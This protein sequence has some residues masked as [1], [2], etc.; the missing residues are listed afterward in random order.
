MS[1]HH[2]HHHDHTGTCP[3]CDYGPFVRNAYWT[4]KLMLA[5]DFTDEQRY[6]IDRFRHHNQHLHGTGVVCGLKVVPHENPECR[7]RFICVQPGSAIDCCGHDILVLETDCIDLWAVPAIK[8]LRDAQDKTPHVLEICIKYRECP[9]EEVPVLYD[10]C[11]CDEDRCAPNRILESYEIGVCVLDKNPDPPPPFPANCCDLWKQSIDGCPDCDTADCLVLATIPNYVVGN[12]IVAELPSPLPPEGAA[13]IDN[14]TFRQLLPS[15][16][17]IKEFL[18]C[19]NL[20]A[21]GTGGGTGPQGPPGPQG[22]SGPAGPAGPAGAPGPAGP[23]GPPGPKGDP[24][25]VDPATLTHICAINWNHGK[26]STKPMVDKGIVI[27]FDKKVTAADLHDQSIRLLF[28]KPDDAD[29]LTMCWCQLPGEF[30]P[31][32]ITPPCN[33]NGSFASSA[34]PQVTAVRFTP[35]EM[36]KG[37]Y[38]VVVIGDYIR[39]DGDKA[40]DAN[41]LPGWLNAR[42]TGDGVEGGTFESWFLI[43]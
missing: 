15:V 30:R 16:Q 38:R 9:T 41:H 17:T 14:V 29:P 2:H 6:V 3:A 23:P 22:P 10:E 25:G 20:C 13:L 31:G 36:P 8:A 39:G 43:E 26:P 21:G 28:E 34:A 7:A 1:H 33:P 4:G 42:P 5:R 24:G 35:R 32:N 12:Q 19:L 37:R 27:T 18:D 40:V 11:D